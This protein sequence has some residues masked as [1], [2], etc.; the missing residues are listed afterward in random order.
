MKLEERLS[1]ERRIA[2]LI[3]ELNGLVLKSAG[4]GRSEMRGYDWSWVIRG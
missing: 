1:G 3:M 2:V 4:A